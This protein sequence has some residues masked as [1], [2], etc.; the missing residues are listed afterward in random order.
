MR[1]VPQAGIFFERQPRETLG[2]A[3]LCRAIT[4]YQPIIDQ[5]CVSKQCQMHAIN[6]ASLAHE[7]GENEEY[8][9][10]GR[11]C[12]ENAIDLDKVDQSRRS[13]LGTSLLEVLD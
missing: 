4:P 9:S 6:L 2:P 5:H 13:N 1:K 12:P 11:E 3:M 7:D 10:C 8:R